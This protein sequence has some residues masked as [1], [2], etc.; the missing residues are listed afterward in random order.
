MVE[1]ELILQLSVWT[2][3]EYNHDSIILE[4]LYAS[5]KDAVKHVICPVICIVG[6]DAVT[7]VVN[8][9]NLR[10]VARSRLPDAGIVDQASPRDVQ[11][12]VQ[13]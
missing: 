1:E 8:A 13:D 11:L 10:S 6:H 2:N 5:I 3:I 7:S 12:L 4:L 9:D